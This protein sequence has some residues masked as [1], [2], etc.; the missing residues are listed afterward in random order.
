MSF[1]FSLQKYE[2]KTIW[3]KNNKFYLS[4]VLWHSM[5]ETKKDNKSFENF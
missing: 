2:K 5:A 1:F 4:L 3:S